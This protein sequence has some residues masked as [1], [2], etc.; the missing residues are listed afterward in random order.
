MDISLHESVL[1]TSEGS[2]L[3]RAKA[4]KAVI[5]IADDAADAEAFL[6]I[7]KAKVAK[8]ASMSPDAAD[9]SSQS[10]SPHVCPVVQA[11]AAEL[12]EE[13]MAPATMGAKAEEQDPVAPG[14]DGAEAAPA[15]AEGPPMKEE[16]ATKKEK[17]EDDTESLQALLANIVHPA[18]VP[19][20]EGTKLVEAS[21]ST[22]RLFAVQLEAW[23]AAKFLPGVGGSVNGYPDLGYHALRIDDKKTMT[24]D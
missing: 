23:M 22:F 13:E 17:V 24:F 1:A 21:A 14:A 5:Q 18:A 16:E 19:V 15:A 12:A 6:R 10:Q 9:E 7:A 4:W 3:A 11:A 20:G 2:D 8:L